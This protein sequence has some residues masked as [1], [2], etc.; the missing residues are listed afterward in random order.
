MMN[1]LVLP[2]LAATPALAQDAQPE[3]NV[4]AVYDALQCAGSDV[5][6]AVRVLD[7]DSR[8]V[9]FE[10]RA[11]VTTDCAPRLSEDA[12]D[13]LRM[14]LISGC[15]GAG[16]DGQLC[17]AIGRDVTRMVLNAS[18]HPAPVRAGLGYTA[19]DDKAPGRVSLRLDDG[20]S[21]QFSARFVDGD[22]F[23]SV[24]VLRPRSRAADTVLS[25]VQWGDAGLRGMI[26]DVGELQLE[27]ETTERNRCRSAGAGV[28]VHMHATANTLVQGDEYDPAE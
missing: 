20:G 2:F 23:Q 19:D 21:A 15:D 18:G 25:C 4:D 9:L 7:A 6:F 26:D 24:P 11:R 3:R 16:L 17:D 1:L 12:A 10:E 27:L 13:A 5:G 8:D 22:R 14:S 28:V